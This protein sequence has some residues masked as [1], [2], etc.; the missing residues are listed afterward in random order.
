MECP[1]P[2]RD[3]RQLRPSGRPAAAARDAACFAE[4]LLPGLAVRS[5]GAGPHPAQLLRGA[6][7]VHGPARSHRRVA[8]LQRLLLV[9]QRVVDLLVARGALLTE[10]LAPGRRFLVLVLGRARVVAGHLEVTRQEGHVLVQRVDLLLDRIKEL[11][12]LQVGLRSALD[13]FLAPGGAQR[14]TRIG[15]SHTGGCELARRAQQSEL[16]AA[17]EPCCIA[18]GASLSQLITAG[19]GRSCAARLWCRSP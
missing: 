16:R 17:Y 5:A 19:S 18:H 14:V 15:S 10:H 1:L 7:S 11:S 12:R 13:G 6:A 4:T 8:C 2:V 3:G 9:G